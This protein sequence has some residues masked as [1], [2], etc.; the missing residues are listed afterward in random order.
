MLSILL[1]HNYKE[2]S[3]KRLRV[4]LICQIRIKR[5]D[6]HIFTFSTKLTFFLAQDCFHFV[7]SR[8]IC[9]LSFSLSHTQNKRGLISIIKSFLIIFP[10]H[11]SGSSITNKFQQVLGNILFHNYATFDEFNFVK[12]HHVEIESLHTHPTKPT[13]LSQ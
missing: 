5:P 9:S 10:S 6:M 1:V 7:A 2:Y 13:C 12:G 11:K 4:Y 3:I 8:N